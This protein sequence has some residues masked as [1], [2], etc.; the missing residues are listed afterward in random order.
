MK[1]HIVLQFSIFIPSRLLCS[2]NFNTSVSSSSSSKKRVGTKSRKPT[3][4]KDAMKKPNDMDVQSTT[5]INSNI[6][7][8]TLDN[9]LLYEKKIKIEKRLNCCILKTILF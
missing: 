6:S 9:T 3:F 8:K 2:G 5:I 1:T 4:L 7:D